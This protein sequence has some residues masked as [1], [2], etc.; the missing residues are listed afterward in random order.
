MRD[1][2]R[3]REQMKLKLGSVD[4]VEVYLMKRAV[5]Q[6]CSLQVSLDQS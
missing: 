2:G 6:C 5:G 4:L 3:T 1:G